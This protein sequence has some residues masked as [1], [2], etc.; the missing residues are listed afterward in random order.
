MAGTPFPDVDHPPR[1]EEVLD[2]VGGLARCWQLLDDWIRETYGLVGE[3]AYAGRQSGWAVRYRRSGKTLV[4]LI[5]RDGGFHAQVVVGPSA[6]EA[7][8]A[9]TLSPGTRAAWNSARAYPDGRWLWLD[10]V[11][12]EMVRDVETLIALKSRPPRRPVG[13]PR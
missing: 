8:A 6:W 5:P 2:A 9:A 10:I 11:D 7:A 13:A 12:E 4:T 1:T 3:P